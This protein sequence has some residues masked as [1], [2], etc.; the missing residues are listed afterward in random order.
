VAQLVDA[1]IG[2]EVV[3]IILRI[4]WDKLEIAVLDDV[5]AIGPLNRV[6]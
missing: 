1:W 4:E 3:L 2:G 6:S 5:F